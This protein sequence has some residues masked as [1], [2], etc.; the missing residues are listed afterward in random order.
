MDR[1]KTVILKTFIL[2]EDEMRV[3]SKIFKTVNLFIPSIHLH[4]DINDLIE[5]D[6]LIIV[7]IN[8]NRAVKWYKEQNVN[9]LNII[10]VCKDL[11][12]SQSKLA[13][14]ALGM[15]EA[16]DQSITCFDALIQKLKKIKICSSLCCF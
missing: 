4:R 12:R 5:V 7:N 10:L 14:N 13:F 1:K 6:G 8:D 9:N 11:K 3:L 15:I 16:I 2:D